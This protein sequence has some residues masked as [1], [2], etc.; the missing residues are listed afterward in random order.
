MHQAP[1]GRPGEPVIYHTQ[2]QFPFRAMTIVGRG[3]D[4]AA[5]VTGL[6][7]AVRAL[8]GSLA[9]GTVQDDG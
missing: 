9:F 2:R 5:V 8:D 6:R 1:I 4:T 3:P 7:A